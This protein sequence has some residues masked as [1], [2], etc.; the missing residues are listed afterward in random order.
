MLRTLLSD[1]TIRLLPPRE[2]EL[3]RKRSGSSFSAQADQALQLYY[4]QLALNMLWTPLFFGGESTD[5]DATDYQ[6]SRRSLL[7]ATSWL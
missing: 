2:R 6:P 1:L 5:S 4:A 7:S 3:I